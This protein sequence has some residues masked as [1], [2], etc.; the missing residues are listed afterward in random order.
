MVFLRSVKKEDSMILFEWINKRSLIILNS[1]FHSISESEH[2]NWFNKITPR[3][4]DLVFFM[5][6][7]RE[8]RKVIGSCQLFNIHPVFRNAELQIRIGDEKFH[9][10]GFGSEAVRQLVEFGFKDLNLHRIYLNVFSDNHRA[11]RA[12]EKCGF[13]K[14]GL[15]RKAAFISGNWVDVA[16]MGILRD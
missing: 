12:Y 13:I 9:G 2:E 7:A 10:Q 3:R 11:I 4:N 6:E 15:L 5:I 14:E 1:H 8:E 16:V